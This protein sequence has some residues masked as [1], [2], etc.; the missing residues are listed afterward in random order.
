MLHAALSA[1][2]N[3][4]NNNN[5]C[6]P[7]SCQHQCS[8]CLHKQT[9][10]RPH[11]VLDNFVLVLQQ[12]GLVSTSS[13]KFSFHSIR[14]FSRPVG[15][16]RGASVIKVNE[17][18]LYN[19]PPPPLFKPVG[20]SPVHHDWGKPTPPLSRIRTR[21]EPTKPLRPFLYCT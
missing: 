20:L 4:N 1:K 9:E 14:S 17:D 13:I 3:D 12:R 10:F 8:R 18:R 7:P 19:C 5:T 15:C 21:S 16:G 2:T 6:T 11:L